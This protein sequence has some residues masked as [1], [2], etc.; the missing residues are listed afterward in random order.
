[1]TFRPSRWVAGATFLLLVPATI[2]L[3]YRGS[4]VGLY[5]YGLV[6]VAF[7]VYLV[8]GIVVL[9]TVLPI[10]RRWERSGEGES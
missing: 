6:P 7:G 1:M 8:I 9:F 5:P 3:A 4:A 2:W 10:I